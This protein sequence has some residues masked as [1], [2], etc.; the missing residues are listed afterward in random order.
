MELP[1]I[2]V[3]ARLQ[4]TSFGDGLEIFIETKRKADQHVKTYRERLPIKQVMRSGTF[5]EILVHVFASFYQEV[6]DP[7]FR[8]QI[9]QIVKQREEANAKKS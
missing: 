7:E 1:D 6:T 2:E 5:K 8:D 3:T 9:R 4:P